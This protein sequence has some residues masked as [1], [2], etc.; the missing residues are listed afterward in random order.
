VRDGGHVRL[1]GTELVAHV[2]AGHTRGCTTWTTNLR[3]GSRTLQVVLLCS[4]TVP[5]DYRLVNNP[6]Y[7][8]AIADYRAQFHFL[9][10][11]APDIYLGSHGGFFDLEEKSKSLRAGAQ[12]N[13]FI[14]PEGYKRLIAAME[15]RFEAVVERQ[16]TTLSQTP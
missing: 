11:L 2:T 6:R 12:K 14:D 5:S 16:S 1:G 8:D 4:P 15:Q 13:P 3:D 10:S 9:E 7:L